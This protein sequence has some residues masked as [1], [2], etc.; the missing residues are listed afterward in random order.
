MGTGVSKERLRRP[1]NHGRSPDIPLQCSITPHRGCEHGC[2]YRFARPAHA[3]LGLS[4]RPG[5]EIRLV[6]RP[7]APDV[8]AREMRARGYRPK[9]LA[10]R[11][12]AITGS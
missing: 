8:L 6:A 1:I 7:G 2:T 12:G 11:S 4:P 10:G 9:P 3:C 5:F